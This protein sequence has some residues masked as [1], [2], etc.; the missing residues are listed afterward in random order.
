MAKAAIFSLLI[1]TVQLLPYVIFQKGLAIGLEVV[2]VLLF[3]DGL[4]YIEIKQ[5]DKIRTIKPKISS[6]WSVL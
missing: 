5:T 6:Y 1:E 4:L 2:K 3:L